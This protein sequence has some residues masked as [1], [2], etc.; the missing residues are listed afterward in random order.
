MAVASE[1]GVLRHLTLFRLS[2]PIIAAVAVGGIVSPDALAGAADSV[3]GLAFD[4][5]DWFFMATVTTLLVLALWLGFGRY[6][7]VR[8][9]ADDARPEFSTPSW[10]AML[11]AAGMG[12]GLLFWGV[13]EPVSH[14]AAP[15]VGPGSTAA[16]AREAMVLTGFHWGLHAW[17]VYCMGAMV[18]AYFGFRHG[19]PYLAGTPIR[20]AF[21]GRWTEPIAKGADLVAVLAVVFGC[22]GST[23]TGVLQLQTGLHLTTGIPLESTLVAMAILVALVASYM[24]SAVTGLDRGVKWLSNINMVLAL[25]LMATVLITGPTAFLLRG[26]VTAVS[27]YASSLVSL[28][29]QSYPY[30]ST[31]GWLESWTLTNFVW[32]IAWAPFVGV[33]VARISKGRTIREFVLGVTL[34]PTVFSLLW[35]VVF[36]GTAI[37]EEMFG[38][39]RVV[40]LVRDDVTAALFALFD[41]LPASSLL[42]TISL[43][44]VFVFLVTSM[45]SATFVLGMLTSRGDPQPSTRRKL[46]WGIALGLLSAALVLS[47]NIQA[48]R[49]VAIL[50]AIPFTLVLL[51]Q[52][53]ALLRT[54]T[55]TRRPSRRCS[56]PSRTRA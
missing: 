53:V 22:A 8:L 50:G 4:A 21:S 47:G 48:V 43:V 28:S 11:F 46:A 42:A 34:V 6:G 1:R 44:L 25:A 41:T 29:L 26:F 45:D 17:G 18:L 20:H 36:G 52:V 37:H 2:L 15:P 55:G 23:G 32:W 39:A 9:G 54:A 13:A 38:D 49:A 31:G 10:L 3:T 7:R 16:S 5:L 14:Y 35:F 12:V 40:E 27:D 33:F 51:L 56:S 30:E 24:T 19:E